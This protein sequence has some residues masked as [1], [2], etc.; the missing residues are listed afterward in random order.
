MARKKV[1]IEDPKHQEPAVDPF[2]ASIEKWVT[3]V[4]D[5]PKASSRAK[6]TA[7]QIGIKARQVRHNI[8]GDQSEGTFFD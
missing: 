4:L 2:L 6:A 5:D 8:A 1:Q 7:A 3:S